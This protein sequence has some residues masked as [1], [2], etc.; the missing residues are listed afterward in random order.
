MGATQ[1]S[2][3]A[4]PKSAPPAALAALLSAP[5]A[6]SLVA[7]ATIVAAPAATVT[8]AVASTPEMPT[9]LA[10]SS[11]ERPFFF[12]ASGSTG[13]SDADAA[14]ELPQPIFSLGDAV[15]RDAA[16]LG[17]APGIAGGSRPRYTFEFFERLSAQNDAA[18]R[19][20][21]V[22]WR[23]RWG[24]A[25]AAAPA[26]AA[27]VGVVATI[28]LR[29]ARRGGDDGREEREERAPLVADDRV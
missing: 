15:G 23:R 19:S 17:V 16:A 14:L 18:R 20:P 8:A 11:L 12:N 7:P 9:P 25:A 13:K 28:A 6:P 2:S 26:G 4:N 3:L 24:S 29:R 10:S 21:A 5:R 1:G 27:V 22:E